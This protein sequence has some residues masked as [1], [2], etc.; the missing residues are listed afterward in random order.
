MELIED[1]IIEKKRQTLWTLCRNM[2]LPYEIEETC[3]S[4][5][6]NVIKRKKR[7]H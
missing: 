2:L 6:H 7:T 3:M 4:C 1:Q 5:G